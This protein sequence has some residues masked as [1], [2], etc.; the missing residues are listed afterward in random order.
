MVSSFSD[1]S[2]SWKGLW[3]IRKGQPYRQVCH[4]TF[5]G[6]K[7]LHR[8][9]QQTQTLY[10]QFLSN[11]GQ[12]NSCCHVNCQRG[13]SVS[14]PFCNICLMSREG[15]QCW[16]WP[17]GSHDGSWMRRVSR[18]SALRYWGCESAE[19]TGQDFWNMCLGGTEE[20]PECTHLAPL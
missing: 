1:V 10:L 20:V 16:W 7:L 12:K 9:L 17:A 5:T 19:A 8:F 6:K 11:G 2:G 14:W 13:T 3:H 18:R 4:V 15:L